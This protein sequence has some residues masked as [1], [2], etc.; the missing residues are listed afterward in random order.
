MS[1]DYPGVKPADV[2]VGDTRC[3]EVPILEVS[4]VAVVWESNHSV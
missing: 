4:V 1:V 2:A 3:I